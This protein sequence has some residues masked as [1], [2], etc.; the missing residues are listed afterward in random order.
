MAEGINLY[1][2]SLPL[3]P[4]SFI[5]LKRVL[6]VEYNSYQ[7]TCLPF[8]ISWVDFFSLFFAKSFYQKKELHITHDNLAIGV[9]VSVNVCLSLYVGP[10]TD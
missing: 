7:L 9:N 5:M 6:K 3:T 1:C 2:K 4:P 8:L 10:V